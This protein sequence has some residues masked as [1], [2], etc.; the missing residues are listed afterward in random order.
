MTP[1]YR[2]NGEGLLV[3]CL[4]SA[5][6]QTFRNFEHII[7]DDG[8][9]DGSEEVIREMAGRDDRI[10]YVRHERNSGL[11]GART[12]EGVLRAR[13]EFVAFL[14]DDSVYEPDFLEKTVAEA[15]ASGADVVVTRVRVLRPDGRWSWAGGWPIT[16]ELLRNIVLIPNGGVLVRRD[17]FDRFGLYDPHLLL[18]V[19][20]DL[21]L[22]LRALIQGARFSVLQAAGGTEGGELSKHS[23]RNTIEWDLGATLAYMQDPHRLA[24]RTARL[25]PDAIDEVDVLD[26][27]AVAPYLCGPQEWR[28]LAEAV[29]RPFLEARP[30]LGFDLEAPADDASLWSRPRRRLLVVSSAMSSYA[31]AWVAALRRIE[32]VIVVHAMESALSQF[33]PEGLHLVVLI[34]CVG[35]AGPAVLA[36]LRGAGTPIL[37]IDAYGRQDGE[38]R[39]PGLERRLWYATAQSLGL[40]LGGCYLSR[41]GLGFTPDQRRGFEALTAFALLVPEPPGA[42]SGRRRREA[43]TE[44]PPGP[45]REPQLFDPPVPTNGRMSW[46]SLGDFIERR[47]GADVLVDPALLDALPA[48]ECQGLAYGLAANDVRLR[49][50]ADPYTVLSPGAENPIGRL[51]NIGR[52]ALACGAVARRRGRAV[53]PLRVVVAL[54]DETGSEPTPHGVILVEALNDLG[55]ETRVILQPDV[56]GG[57]VERFVEAFDADILLCCGP[58]P[59][60]QIRPDILQVTVRFRAVGL[61]GGSLSGSGG[62][63]VRGDIDPDSPPT[64][65]TRALMKLLLDAASSGPSVAA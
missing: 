53:R 63:S 6:A 19:T 4:E 62:E 43:A 23:I 17:F 41:P 51:E 2:R 33:P 65:V 11:P 13:G 8:S 37:N 57:S 9:S 55:A 3:R 45:P 59:T 58:R 46:P 1:T 42:A 18:R 47:A 60:P 12:N 40:L 49:S 29:Y 61:T 64:A 38:S 31:S 16:L 36:K 34:D 48:A 50:A 27:A 21:D 7:I 35:P 30:A 32:D 10:V 44:P 56:A 26:P 22:W 52:Y 25:R 28:T 14:F 39:H 54:N 20:C 24:E 15:Q 5:A